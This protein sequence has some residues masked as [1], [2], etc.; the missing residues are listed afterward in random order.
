MA[1]TVHDLPR[2]DV[3]VRDLCRVCAENVAVG[4]AAVF[5]VTKEA[6]ELDLQRC[7]ARVE[8]NRERGGRGIP[9]TRLTIIPDPDRTPSNAQPEW[10]PVTKCLEYM[11]LTAVPL[12]VRVMRGEAGVGIQADAK[13]DV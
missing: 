9:F 4:R 2:F 8:K 1:K 6:L 12:Y 7:K 13:P 5:C 10:I 3:G 11:R